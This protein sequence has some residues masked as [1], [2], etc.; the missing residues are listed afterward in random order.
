MRSNS[1]LTEKVDQANDG[2]ERRHYEAGPL[3]SQNEAAAQNG[4]P[5]RQ[6]TRSAT[7][8]ATKNA[9]G[10]GTNIGWSG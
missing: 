1:W 8:V 9:M 2:S 3:R 6:K 4:T 5:V 7:K 10:K